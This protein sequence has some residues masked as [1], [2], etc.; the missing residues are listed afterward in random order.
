[1]REVWAELTAGLTLENILI[2]I[3]TFMATIICFLGAFFVTVRCFA[4]LLNLIAGLAN[5]LA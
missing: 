3:A 5:V 2:G 1:M 4:G